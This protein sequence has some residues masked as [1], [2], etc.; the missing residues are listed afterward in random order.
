MKAAM[1]AGI[2]AM[3]VSGTSAT[4]AF[5]V[6]SKHIKNGS[7]QTVDISAKAKRALRGNRGP[8]GFRGL[9][10][11]QG[12]PGSMGPQG[13][14]GD[15]GDPGPVDV[16]ERWF[17]TSGFGAGCSSSPSAITATSSTGASYFLTMDVPAGSYVV[18]AEVIVSAPAS[19]A[20]D[21]RCQ[22]RTTNSPGFGGE[23]KVTV[24]D[25]TDTLTVVFGAPNQQATQMGLKCWTDG[26]TGSV[27]SV[28][29]GEVIALKVGNITQSVQP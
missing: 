14:K 2:V 16:F 10:G 23:S 15:K 22:A 18:M 1:I 26:G 5:V 28:V 8:R 29:Y 17:C 21:V 25:S 9:P 13:P 6:T 27:P 20:W 7:I 24:G 19:S 11:V 12:L 3:L 4:A